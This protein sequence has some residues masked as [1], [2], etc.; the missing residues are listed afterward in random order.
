[1]KQTLD[2]QESDMEFRRDIRIEDFDPEF[3]SSLLRD[4]LNR[5]HVA[6]WW[7]D[8]Q[9]ALEMSLRQSRNACAIIAVNRTPVGYICWQTLSQD[10]R[11]AAGLTDLSAD[12]V[13]IDILVGDPEVVGQGI[14]TAALS[15]LLERLRSEGIAEVAGVGTSVANQ[16]AIR[17]FEKAGFSLFREFQDPEFGLSQYMTVAMCGAV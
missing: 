11:K 12:C 9:R 8:P 2:G 4:W 6:R 14:G 10:E 3:H 7:G 13:D 15:L 17:A 16:D 5:P 1:M